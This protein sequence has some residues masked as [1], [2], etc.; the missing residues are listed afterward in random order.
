VDPSFFSLPLVGRVGEGVSRMRPYTGGG[1]GTI[2]ASPSG[3]AAD[4]GSAIPGSNPG[5]P[6]IAFIPRGYRRTRRRIPN[7]G[8]CPGH[9]LERSPFLE[10]YVKRPECQ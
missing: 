9:P 5:A 1:P 10:T 8:P 4:F 6:A 2:G 7:P 3:K